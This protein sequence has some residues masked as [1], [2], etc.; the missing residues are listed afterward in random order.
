[1][2]PFMDDFLFL[3]DSYEAALEL[4]AHLESLL[5][6]L[7][8]A[9]NPTKG[10]WTP[11]Q[12]GEHLGLHLDLKQGLFLA[13]PAKLRAISFLARDLLCRSTRDKRWV[14]A[15][16]LS[17]LAGRA[18]FLYLAIPVARYYL[19]ELHDVLRTKSSWGGKV[20]VTKQLR[21]DLQWWVS[22]PAENNGRSIFRPV[23]TVYLHCDSSDYGWGAVLNGQH[24]ARGFWTGLDKDQHITYK[25]LKAVR[26][27]VTTFL[28]YLSNR[29][30]LLHEDNQAVV[31][32]LTHLTSRSAVMMTELR[33]L[34]HLLD[35]HGISIRPRYIASA[36]NIWADRLSRELDTE[37]WQLNPRIFRYLDSR[38][39]PHTVD[40]FASMTNTLLPRYNSRWLDPNTE[41]VDCLHLPDLNWTAERNWCNPPWSLLEDLVLKLRQSGAAATVI[42]PTWP[43]KPWHQSLLDLASEYLVYP[44]SADIFSP[45]RSL[46]PGTVGPPRWSV[47]AFR[48]PARAG[49]SS[50][51]SLLAAARR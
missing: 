9:R 34:W 28:P 4:R 33:K 12:E 22:V 30:V 24:H 20:R 43:G 40:R 8:L 6:T 11:T 51:G 21:R 25:E 3:A 13:P 7:G 45:G 1:M 29:N 23:E 49:S 26:H 15:R 16:A 35:A 46:K 47:S 2:L 10:Y 36:A 27:A 39:G 37:D 32:I 42:A 17:A 48:I 44:P 41:A 19:R 31:S 5:T 18:Q 50:L 14:S 38:W